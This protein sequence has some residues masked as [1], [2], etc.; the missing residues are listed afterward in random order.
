[1]SPYEVTDGRFRDTVARLLVPEMGTAAVAPLLAGLV[2]FARPRR[3]LEV[4][5][6]YT[7]PFLA[8]AVASVER[9]VRA[10][11][12]ALAAK[13]APFLDSG[14]DL[15]DGWLNAA[16]SLAEPG[17]YLEPYRPTFV[18][19][20]DLSIVESSAPQV[21]EVLRQL[22]LDEVVTVV[23]ADLRSCADRL[24]EGFV[25]IDLA[26]IDA[27]ECLY[28]F[29]HFWELINPDGGLVAMH[30]LLTYPEGE[31]ILRYL[32]R[33][34]A[35]HPGEMELVNIL[36]PHKRTQNSITLLRRTGGSKPRRW[37]DTGGRIRYD[38]ELR[39]T[40]AAQAASQAAAAGGGGVA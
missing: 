8:A 21:R 10:E 35:D 9:Q 23:N 32:R 37:A 30:Y 16:P 13:S 11:A 27:W 7:T 15:D 1:V 36:E 24:P 20:D 34:Q 2:Q 5:M 18:A 6:G 28:F 17:F 33:F 29:D 19:V 31:A 40:T 38:A 25:D 4:G 3:V 26:W 12:P 39:E 14:T 22:G